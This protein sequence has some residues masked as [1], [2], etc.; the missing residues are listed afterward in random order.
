VASVSFKLH[1]LCRLCRVYQNWMGVL[2]LVTLSQLFDNA[3]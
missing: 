2:D 3:G 1:C